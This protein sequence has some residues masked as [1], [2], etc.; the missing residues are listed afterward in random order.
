VHTLIVGEAEIQNLVGIVD[1]SAAGS[2][3]IAP[4][5]RL[6]HQDERIAL[7]AGKVLL[8]NVTSNASSLSSGD[9]QIGLR[10]V[11]KSIKSITFG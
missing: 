8:D 10:S 3:E 11:L 4:V 1:F 2:R 7:P 9:S 5:K 6:Q